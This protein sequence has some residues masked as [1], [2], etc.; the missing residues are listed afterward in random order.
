MIDY[1]LTSM[2]PWRLRFLTEKKL[3]KTIEFLLKKGT[4][5][6]RIGGENT[7]FISENSLKRLQEVDFRVDGERI[8]VD[9]S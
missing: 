7:L 1:D 3:K 8:Y 9:E 2:L 5:F 6:A 4:S